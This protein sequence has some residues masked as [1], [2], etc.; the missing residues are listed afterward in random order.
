MTQ[1]KKKLGMNLM[2]K[3]APLV[4]AVIAACL[5]VCLSRADNGVPPLKTEFYN[6]KVMPLA[7]IVSKH[8][9][10]LDADAAPHWL[11]LV[12]EDGRIYPLVKDAGSRMFFKDA[13]LLNRPVRL[14]G[15]LLKG[16][17]LLQVVGVHT[18][19]Q[20]R[21]HEVYYWCDICTIRT[22]EAG[23]CDCCGGPME[24]REVPI[25]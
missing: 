5:P 9:A 17:N 22:Y 16:S 8:G 25:K 6:G 20:G 24:F 14:T 4:A 10:K 1:M 11:A 12:S 3:R 7:D 19:L 13:T 21:L 18:Y 2:K 15:R 23:I